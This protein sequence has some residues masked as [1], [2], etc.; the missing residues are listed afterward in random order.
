MGHSGTHR[1]CRPVVSE[2]S[3]TRLDDRQEPCCANHSCAHSHGICGSLPE[4]EPPAL[5]LLLSLSSPYASLSQVEHVLRLFSLDFFKGLVHIVRLT[6]TLNALT[7]RHQRLIAVGKH[8]VADF[9]FLV[10]D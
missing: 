8:K 3:G 5:S 9:V 10:C 6:V 7:L 1:T 2:G 4:P